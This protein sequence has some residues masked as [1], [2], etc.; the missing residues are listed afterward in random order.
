MRNNLFKFFVLPFLFCINSVF[1]QTDTIGKSYA[2]LSVSLGVNLNYFDLAELKS[3]GYMLN[4][5]SDLQFFPLHGS[6]SVGK[7]DKYYGSLEF[8]GG[9]QN[10]RGVYTQGLNTFYKME[11][12]WYSTRWAL[13]LN[14]AI[15]F[16]KHFA[17]DASAGTSLLFSIATSI[18]RYDS[19]TQQLFAN[20]LITQHGSVYLGTVFRFFWA[21]KRQGDMG[22]SLRLGYNIP[23]SKPHWDTRNVYMNSIPTIDLSGPTISLM[24]YTWSYSSSYMKKLL[25]NAPRA[26]RKN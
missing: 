7:R 10:R 25:K 11:V 13:Y 8:G 21:T 17:M 12:S 19:L 22:F 18:N 5:P 4:I 2:R 26:P 16:K 15:V 14:R 6:F 20:A 3:E 24:W 23:T 1:A 9:G